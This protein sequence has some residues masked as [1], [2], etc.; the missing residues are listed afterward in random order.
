MDRDL[1]AAVGVLELDDAADLGELRS[2]LRVAGLE[3]LDDARKAVR[4]V[5]AGH[6]A[7]VERPHRELGAGLADRLRGD[8]A[9]RVADLAH[10]ARGEEDAVAGRHTPNSLRHLSTERTGIWKSGAYSPSSSTS[11]WSS[12]FVITVALGRGDRLAG[13]PVLERLVDVDCATIR[14]AASG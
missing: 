6:T 3:D 7:G 14:P 13:L 8:D 4:D 10:L 2:A 5:R 9:D 12:A 11:R 1:G